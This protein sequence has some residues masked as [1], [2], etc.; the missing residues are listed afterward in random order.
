[1]TPFEVLYERKCTTPISWDNLVEKIMVGPEILQ[2]ME[3]MVKRVQQNLKE[4]QY[5]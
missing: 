5:R 2:E 1:M 4:S 3:R